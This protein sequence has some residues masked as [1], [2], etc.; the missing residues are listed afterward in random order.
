M[1]EAIFAF[2]TL[3]PNTKKW[4]VEKISLEDRLKLLY[5]QRTQGVSTIVKMARDA[6]A[7]YPI[8]LVKSLDAKP[9]PLYLFIYHMQNPGDYQRP[10][11]RRPPDVGGA[12]NKVK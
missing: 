2:S 8:K 9:S 6:I 5:P 12:A 11:V 3:G 1:I 10:S 7:G 4:N